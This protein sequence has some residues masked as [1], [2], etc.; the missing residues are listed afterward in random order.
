VLTIKGT[1]LP[2]NLQQVVLELVD[3]YGRSLNASRI[4]DVTSLDTQVIDKTLPY[5]VDASTP[6]YLVI[7]QSHDVLNNPVFFSHQY[8]I[9]WNGPA[10]VYTELITLNP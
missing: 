1:Y 4:V 6:A 8:P 7:H 2:V 9:P 5:K 10:Y 3:I